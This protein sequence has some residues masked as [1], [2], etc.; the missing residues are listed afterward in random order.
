MSL[1]FV[2]NMFTNQAMTCLKFNGCCGGVTRKSNYKGMM[3]KLINFKQCETLKDHI[4]VGPYY[5]VKHPRRQTS[6]ILTQ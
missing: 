1:V 4:V 3:F 5:A 6:L 2:L